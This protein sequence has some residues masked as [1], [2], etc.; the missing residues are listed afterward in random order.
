[1]SYDEPHVEGLNLNML[2]ESE[3][4]IKGIRKPS[5]YQRDESCRATPAI[6]YATDPFEHPACEGG[7]LTDEGARLL[8]RIDEGSIFDEILPWPITSD[9]YIKICQMA[10][11]RFG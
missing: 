6:G 3:N 4:F 7:H 5:R 9:E 10:K 1:M 8:A 11:R 2:I